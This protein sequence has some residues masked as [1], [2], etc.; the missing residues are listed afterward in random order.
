[1]SNDL[2]H[3]RKAFV[4]L[5]GGIDSTTCLAIALRDYEH[6][7][8]V[9]IDYGQKHVKEIARAM[10]ISSLYNV[11]HTVIRLPGVLSG[12]DVMLTDDS[13]EI[14][15]ISYDEIKGI[16][17]TFVPFRNGAMLSILAAHAQKY[18]LSVMNEEGLDADS[19]ALKDLCTVF[20]GAHAE[21]AHNWAYPDCTPE[22]IGTIGAAIYIGTYRTVRV[23]APLMHMNKSE[24]VATGHKLNAPLAQT[25]SC[26]AGRDVHCGV[27]PTCRSRKEAF[28]AADVIDKTTYADVDK[29]IA[30]TIQAE[31][32]DS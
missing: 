28:I 7:E 6:V 17:P 18:V 12:E 27:C 25:W 1:M 31:I 10:E 14:P 32:A 15:D 9:S 26:Y 30:E 5:S 22:F 21:D 29:E 19:E 13:V 20:I 23:S 3:K 2:K 8:A 4:L 16:S 11:K 24:V